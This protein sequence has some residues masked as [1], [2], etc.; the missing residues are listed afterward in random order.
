[1]SLKQKSLDILLVDGTEHRVAILLADSRRGELELKKRGL[2]ADQGINLN[3]AIA[4]S[5]MARTG[6]TDLDFDAF[7]LACVDLQSATDEPE[8]GVPVDPTAQAAPSDSA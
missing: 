5:A 2:T 3:A 4:W 6:Q 1:M 8:D 7:S